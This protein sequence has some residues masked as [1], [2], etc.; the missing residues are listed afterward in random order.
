MCCGAGPDAPDAKLH[1]MCPNRPGPSRPVTEP[2]CAHHLPCRTNELMERVGPGP[3]LNNPRSSHAVTAVALH[4]PTA[5][6]APEDLCDRTSCEE[7]RCV[8]QLPA[9]HARRSTGTNTKMQAGESTTI[10]KG[11][12]REEIRNNAGEDPCVK[13]VPRRTVPTGGLWRRWCYPMRKSPPACPTK[14]AVTKT[15]CDQAGL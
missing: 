1:A 9:A 7:I 15:D 12:L 11:R 5:D 2:S 14:P 8:D 10:G 4:Q 3:G 13:A 6:C